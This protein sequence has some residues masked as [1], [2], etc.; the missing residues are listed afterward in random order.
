MN[1]VVKELTGYLNEM[2]QILPESR[3][4]TP[5]PVTPSSG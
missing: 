4:R 5:T 2:T 1:H 3:D